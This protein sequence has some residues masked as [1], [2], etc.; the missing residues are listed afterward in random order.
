MSHKFER[1]CRKFDISL[2]YFHPLTT[3]LPALTPVE[4]QTEYDKRNTMIKMIFLCEWQIRVH[5]ESLIFYLKIKIVNEHIRQSQDIH[6][7][8]RKETV[9]FNLHSKLWANCHVAER[10]DITAHWWNHATECGLESWRSLVQ[11]SFASKGGTVHSHREWRRT[12]CLS[13]SFIFSRT[14]QVGVWWPIHTRVKQKIDV[15]LLKPFTEHRIR[16]YKIH[17]S[18]CAV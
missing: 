3:P 2:Y 9:C 4:T 11:T 13:L 16:T 18:N 17:K 1:F 6:E 12:V 15:K 8:L 7:L 5:L 10:H 14:E